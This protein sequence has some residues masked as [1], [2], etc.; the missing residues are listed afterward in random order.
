MQQTLTLPE[1]VLTTQ[2]ADKRRAFFRRKVVPWLFVLPIL[3]INILVV[4]A[5][6]LSSVYFS[7]TKWSGLGAAEWVGLANYQTLFRDPGFHHAFMNN[8]L[9]LAMF[10]AIPISM[11][12]IAASLLAPIKRGAIVFRLS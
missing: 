12:L 4:A 7:M 11:A 5:P 3:L 1:G 8:V 10:L 2:R 9:W 6:A